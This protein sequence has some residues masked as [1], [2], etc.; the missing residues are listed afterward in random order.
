MI[1]KRMLVL[2]STLFLLTS[3]V[4]G[5]YNADFVYNYS[6]VGNHYTFTVNVSNTSTSPDTAALDYFRII[7]DAD[8]VFDNYANVA[9]NNGRGWTTW[10]DQ[11][12]GGF[13]GS[14]GVVHA[15]D[16]IFGSGGGG[17]D[18]GLLVNGFQFVFDYS[19]SVA[20]AQ[21]LLSWHA[22]YG[23]NLAG[24]GIAVG[25]PQNPDYWIMGAA[26]GNLRYRGTPPGVPEPG[27]FLLVGVGLAG[28][29]YWRKRH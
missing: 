23:A 20:P 26:D 27:T 7:L 22:E 11:P 5:A 15:D 12:L 24:N 9:W 6:Q 10:E 17:I 18:P 4:W 14:P 29:V 13:G 25:D 16:S 21:Q 19:G 1:W 3:P 28:M 2:V 8:P